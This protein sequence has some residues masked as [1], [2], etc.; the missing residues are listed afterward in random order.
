M[1]E[2]KSVE[3]PEPHVDDEHIRRVRGEM[4]TRVLE[5]RESDDLESPLENQLDQRA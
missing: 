4:G 5:I 2:L 3:H 1:D